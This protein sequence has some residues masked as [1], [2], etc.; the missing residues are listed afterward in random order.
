VKR[1]AERNLKECVPVFERSS[2]EEIDDIQHVSEGGTAGALCD[3]EMQRPVLVEVVQRCEVL[4][5]SPVFSTVRLH[6][7]DETPSL[8]TYGTNSV[9]EV[10][11]RGPSTPEDREL[12][13]FLDAFRERKP[14]VGD[15]EIEGQVVEG[16]AEV[17]QT[18]SDESAPLDQRRLFVSMEDPAALLVFDLV[19]AGNAVC[20]GVSEGREAALEVRSVHVGPTELL[21]DP[22]AYGLSHGTEGLRTQTGLPYRFVKA[23]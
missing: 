13:F 10:T 2:V 12:G 15:G 8:W 5:R 23:I 17:E 19:L 22:Y 3:D 4:E 20:V 6:P 1:L 9:V 18:L 16:A 14:C 11:F 21:A 7:L